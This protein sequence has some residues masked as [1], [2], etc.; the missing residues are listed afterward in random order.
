MDRRAFLSG[1]VAT[2][3]GVYIPTKTFFLPPSCGWSP[4]L[5]EADLIRA[6][7]AAWSDGM[8]VRTIHADKSFMGILLSLIDREY[9]QELQHIAPM[10][11]YVSDFGIS[12]IIADDSVDGF[13]LS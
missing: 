1:L 3:A 2:A 11:L 7:E 12:E 5:S 13:W 6:L 10:N 9:P 8:S 4:G